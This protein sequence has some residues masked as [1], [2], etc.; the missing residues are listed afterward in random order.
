MKRVQKYKCEY[1]PAEFDDPIECMEHENICYPIEIRIQKNFEN[2][3]NDIA[4]KYNV[5][6]HSKNLT[7]SEETADNFTIPNIVFS[8]TIFTKDNQTVIINE[9]IHQFTQSAFYDMIESYIL[10]AININIEGI[11]KESK[12]QVLYSG[13]Y[14]LNGETWNDLGRKLCGRKVRIQT[15]GSTERKHNCSTDCP[16]CKCDYGNN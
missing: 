12:D 4:I 14:T 7:F 15:I 2:A 9:I 11:V 16:S 6:I 1:C 13:Q 5:I 10:K 8:T 3:L